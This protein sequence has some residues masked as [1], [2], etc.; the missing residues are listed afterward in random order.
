MHGIE[1][2][3]FNGAAVMLVAGS[4]HAAG[5]AQHSCSCAPALASD[6]QVHGCDCPAT[7]PAC[8]HRQLRQLNCGV[9]WPDGGSAGR[10]DLHHQRWAGCCCCWVAPACCLAACLEGALPRMHLCA[11]LRAGQG[12][13]Q[14]NNGVQTKHQTFEASGNKGM[15]QAQREGSHVRVW[16]KVCRG[17]CW[18]RGCGRL[19]RA[20]GAAV[21]PALEQRAPCSSAARCALALLPLLTP[22]L[23]TRCRCPTTS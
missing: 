4:A 14:H 15:L 13:Q 23:P 20:L 22:L 10:S 6:L 17:D 12:G 19:P 5:A 1:L 2:D 16:L 18:W 9:W 3:D 21:G 11:A 7:L 8:P